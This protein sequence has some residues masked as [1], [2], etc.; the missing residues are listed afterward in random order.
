M[1][2]LLET[3]TVEAVFNAPL[4]QSRDVAN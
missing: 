2:P 3:W 4:Q 1:Q